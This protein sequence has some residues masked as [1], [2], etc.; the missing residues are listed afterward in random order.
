MQLRWLCAEGFGRSGVVNFQIFTV[1]LIPERTSECGEQAW[2]LKDVSADA[3]GTIRRSAIW[4]VLNHRIGR[5]AA[6]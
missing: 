2:F 5:F 6:A 4:R 3:F 1:Q